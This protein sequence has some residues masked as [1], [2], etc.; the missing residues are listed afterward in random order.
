MNTSGPVTSPSSRFAIPGAEFRPAAFWFWNRIPGED[1]IRHGLAEMK[2]AGLG[3]FMIQARLSLPRRDYLSPA[4][5]DACRY[6]FAEA[7]KIGLEAVIYDEYAWMSGHGGGRTVAGADHLR[8]RHLF[9]ARGEAE[10]AGV[11]S[12]GQLEL[13]V[14]GI[15]SG[16][17]DFLGEAA[18]DWIYEGG[19]ARWDDWTLVSALAHGDGANTV[20]VE[21]KILAADASGCRI[22]VDAGDLTC[23]MVT[24]FVSAR[25]ASSRMINYLLPEA[26]QRF[27]ETVYAPL[28]EAA[29]AAGP[30]IARAF[31]FDHPYA[32][33]YG[34]HEHCG[35][36]GHSLLWSDDFGRSVAPG[37]LLALVGCVGLE[38]ARRR[39]AFFADHA[40]RMHEAFF[41]TLRRWC[42]ERGF[43][44]TGHELLSHVGQWGLRGGLGALDPRGMPGVDH[45]GLDAFRTVTA[46]DAAD[47]G[48]QLAAKLGDSVARSNGRSRCIVEQ[49]ST[50]REMARPGLA[51][52]WDL[53]IERL[54][55]QAIRHT[56]LG[57]RQ[58]LF[59]AVYL[60]DGRPYSANDWRANPRFDFPPGLNF[61]PWWEDLPEVFDEVARLSAFVEE[62]EPLR[63]VAL[64]YP[65]AALWQEGGDPPSA[66]HF[67]WWAEALARAGIGYDVLDERDLE[68]GTVVDGDLVTPGGRYGMV[69]LPDA[70]ILSAAATIER[71]RT[72]LRE[73]GRLFASG[74]LPDGLSNGLPN[75]LVETSVRHLPAADQTAVEG[76]VRS[77]DRP[78]PSLHLEAAPA[79][80]VVARHGT[81]WRLA[82]FN[83]AAEPRMLQLKLGNDA[84]L[85]EL[86]NPRSGTVSPFPLPPDERIE[87]PAQGLICLEIHPD[88]RQRGARPGERPRAWT[89]ALITPIELAS[90]WEFR[91]VGAGDRFVPISVTA[92]WERQGF[93]NHSCAGIYRR[94][95][96]LPR[97]KPDQRW[98]L[99]LDRVAETVECRVDGHSIGRR[100]FGEKRFALE[101]SGEILVELH[102]RNTGANRYY[103]DT[104]FAADP[105]T[106]SGL[107]GP[108]RLVAMESR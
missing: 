10:G 73:G 35:E 95:I 60:D 7:A 99:V 81:G 33:F 80:N 2:K 44:F 85:A 57:A 36:L 64:L 97:L 108:P 24:V 96:T 18:C 105:P 76:F 63:P 93:P 50:G 31:F 102:V 103:A 92:G 94:R 23:P 40:R 30:G 106:P 6:A 68:R 1:E 12:D 101:T 78:C 100:L 34:W 26:A 54:R 71:L 91:A 48:S 67:G 59:H 104:P 16:F 69:I 82:A 47:Y 87:L 84:M 46:V 51:G 65:L 42:D 32:G 39:L 74:R 75:A 25:C 21:A 43:D 107:L 79:W 89:P 90:G 17:L 45:F 8:E 5:L 83:E 15:R 70:H 13:T 86:W 72:F 11:G 55:A 52:Q 14:S 19:E 61:Q 62:G 66:E 27:A 53:T 4:Y 38:T 9:W 3:T 88:A 77:L 20:P 56:L 98:D 22:A 28:A 49:Y 58:F 37:D 29:E 41:G